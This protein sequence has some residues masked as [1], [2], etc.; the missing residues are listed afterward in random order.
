MYA[1][2]GIS[3]VRVATVA[4]PELKSARRKSLTITEQKAFSVLSVKII[5][6]LLV[7]S[8][9]VLGLLTSRGTEVDEL[10]SLR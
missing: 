1:I 9:Q 8:Y 6:I 4:P 7:V 3:R 5:A 10:F 2:R